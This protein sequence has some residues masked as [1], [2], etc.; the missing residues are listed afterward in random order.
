MLLGRGTNLS[1][2]E[3]MSNSCEYRH[4]HIV[5]IFRPRTVRESD[6]NI[7]LVTN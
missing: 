4:L 1:D 6:G 7:G 5:F 2:A 3:W